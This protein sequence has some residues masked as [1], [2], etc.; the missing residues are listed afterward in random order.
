VNTLRIIAVVVYTS[1]AYAYGALAL[2][3]LQEWWTGQAP[4]RPEPVP[5]GW[6]ELEAV[7]TALQLVSLVWFIVLAIMTLV[8]FSG[9]TRIWQLDV[10]RA[11]LG[12][13]FPP[14][15]M[16][17]TYAEVAAGRSTP[18]PSAW[19][20]FIWLMY[21]AMHG[22]VVWSLLVFADVLPTAHQL[23]SRTL[24]VAISAGF[25][26]A[27]I[28]AMALVGQAPHRK[29]TAREQQ[30]RRWYVV[31]F[32]LVVVLF[33]LLVALVGRGR[34]SA[35]T[36]AL[37]L[38]EIG[39]NSLPL[40]F[41]FVGAYFEHRFEFFDLF[42]K[43]G[44]SLLLTIA[45]L[46]GAFTLLLPYTRALNSSPAAPWIYAIVLLPVVTA[47]P[48]L[49]GRISTTLDRRWLGRRFTTVEA[50]TR[51]L[52]ELRSATNEGQLV[53]RAEQGLAGIFDAEVRVQLSPPQAPPPFVVVEE[54]EM[55]PGDAAAGRILL[56]AR[57]SEAP[58]FREDVTL[59]SS[60]AHILASVV[61]NHRLQRQG[62]EQDQRARELSLH[63]SRSE[64]KA[65]R[66]QINPHF[67][68]NALNAIAGL[69]HKDPAV[70]DRTIEQLAD[71][72]RYALR[73]AESEWALLDDELEFVRAY[74][75]VERARF[76][77]RL[78]IDV[79]L[80]DEVRG[81]RVPTMMVQTLVENAV[82]HGVALV[83]GP[84]SVA[85]NARR[86]RDQLIV[87]VADTGPG[88]EA[89][90][91]ARGP[92]PR[93]RSRRPEAKGQAPEGREQLPEAG[94]QG[95]PKTGGYGL[96]NVR[97]RLE[98]YFGDAA[99]LTIERDGDR[100]RTIVS[101]SLPLELHAGRHGVGAGSI[102]ESEA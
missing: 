26:T 69:I 79:R 75:E 5:A 45:V 48:W 24:T 97:Q 80:D 99:A 84:A 44:L 19:R 9:P 27:A 55:R 64:L 4:A 87:T 41:L 61:D 98:G 6:R 12:F 101:V 50:V 46:A 81:A 73:G 71:V 3:S 38:V 94:G 43:R 70:A 100:G 29:E 88:F 8:Q 18:L 17:I 89:T 37:G 2:I 13:S 92:T 74:L 22:T 63:A 60:L 90:S 42:V 72:F 83:R 68:F 32:G 85:V 86:D 33:G 91:E 51:F 16:H 23:A 25:I 11:W 52:A 96:S 76:G 57:A 15:I 28:Y 39:A 49:Y 10:L 78:T 56:G 30:L 62:Q 58:Y 34:A 77:S 66:A 93:A 21:L 82:K 14:L 1:G 36:V 95:R 20:A 53:E 102:K 31:L 67:L 59:L 40:P 47:L 7:G 54:V 35:G 65:L